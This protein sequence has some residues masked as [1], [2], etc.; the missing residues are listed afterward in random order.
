MSR[1][2]QY[3]HNRAD[4]L[5]ILR[6]LTEDLEGAGL[7]PPAWIKRLERSR[8]LRPTAK[9]GRPKVQAHKSNHAIEE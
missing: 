4:E 7:I 5:Y 2:N 1:T 9:R 6:E 8:S 3:Y